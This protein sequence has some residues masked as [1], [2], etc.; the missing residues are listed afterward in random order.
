M[1][2]P[3]RNSWIRPS[4]HLLMSETGD[5]RFDVAFLA[6]AGAE[7]VDIAGP[8]GVFEYSLT[9]ATG[10]SPFSLSL[11]AAT[12]EPL[13]LSGGMRVIPERTF[14]DCTRP[15]IVVVPA[16]GIEFTHELELT[17]DLGHGLV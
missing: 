13:V 7:L 4:D 17:R 8:W 10:R 12:N 2:V 14:A 9:P 11:V 3:A 15:D 16:I 6:A 5:R 1:R